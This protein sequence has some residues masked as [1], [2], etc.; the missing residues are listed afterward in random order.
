MLITYF[1]GNGFDLN[2]NLETKFTDFYD[3]IK[4][5]KL[6]EEIKNNA[7]YS[8]INDDRDKWSDFEVELGQL[9]FNYNQETK[10]KLFDDIENFRED[11]IIYMIKQNKLFSF[12]ENK[13]KEILAHSLSCYMYQLNPKEKDNLL[14]IYNLFPETRR[15]NFINFNYTDTLEKI[16]GQFVKDESFGTS[17]IDNRSYANILGDV[18]PIH[19]QLNTGM[20]LGVNDETQ[21]NSKIFDNEEKNSL[22]KPLI[23]EEYRDDANKKVEDSINQSRVIVIYG[24][25]LGVTDKKWWVLIGKW[26]EKNANNRLIIYTYDKEFS[27]SSPIKY[28]RKRK[29]FE[30]RFIEFSYDLNDQELQDK[31]NALRSKIYLISNSDTDFK[32]STSVQS[33]NNIVIDKNLANSLT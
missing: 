2:N 16:V 9:T 17:N 23:N 4:K 22:I 19:K 32:F 6:E 26:L 11:F 1:V 20:F 21:I 7:I 18:I 24:M 8:N 13:V 31:I 10:E 28:L 14:S 5:T 29:Q 27:K 15:Y 12:D 3:Y 25:S 33:T 30:N